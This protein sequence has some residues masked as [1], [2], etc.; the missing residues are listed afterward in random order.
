M[1]FSVYFEYFCLFLVASVGSN[2][3]IEFIRECGPG[4]KRLYW[5]HKK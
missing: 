4:L 2:F 1:E 3:V 5:S